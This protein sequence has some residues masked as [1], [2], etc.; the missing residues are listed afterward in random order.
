[1]NVTRGVALVAALVLGCSSDDGTGPCGSGGTATA[2][3][4]CDRF[5]A[6]ASSPITAG[7]AVAWTWRGAEGHNVTFEDGQGSSSTKTSGT[8]SRSFSS[9][10]S[11]RYRCTIH[12]TGF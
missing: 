3:N 6:P 10:G 1:M 7:A 4:V 8:H 5:F 11:F 2:V 12:S 9:A